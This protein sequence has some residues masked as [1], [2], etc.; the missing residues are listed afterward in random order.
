MKSIAR[1]GI[2]SQSGTRS[3]LDLW[4]YIDH[5][6]I[7]LSNT[8]NEA[9][10]IILFM[11]MQEQEIDEWYEQPQV[12]PFLHRKGSTYVT[13]HYYYYY[14]DTNYYLSNTFMN[15]QSNTVAIY[16]NYEGY[17][18][19]YHSIYLLSLMSNAQPFTSF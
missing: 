5:L 11:W 15:L 16:S 6:S 19:S 18:L 1:C 7:R 17:E 13:S 14:H 12:D 4:W 9:I 3:S 2:R 8:G 10:I